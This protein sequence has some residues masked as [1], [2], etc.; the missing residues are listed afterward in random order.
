MQVAWAIYHRE[1]GGFWRRCGLSSASVFLTP[2][3]AIDGGYANCVPDREDPR[4]GV[5]KELSNY[6]AVLVTAL[7]VHERIKRPFE[8][9]KEVI[10]VHRLISPKHFELSV[11]SVPDISVV[12]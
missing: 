9:S 10:E 8:W 2:K 4:D 7:A 12:S 1:E 3:H 5:D 11:P 6:K